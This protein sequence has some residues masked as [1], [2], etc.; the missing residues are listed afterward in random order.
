MF[1]MEQIG[2]QYGARNIDLTGSRL[3]AFGGNA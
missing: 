2:L 3:E 1:L